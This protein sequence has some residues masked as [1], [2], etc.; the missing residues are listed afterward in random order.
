M[1]LKVF[2]KVAFR[3]FAFCGVGFRT[4]A[5][6]LLGVTAASAMN[7]TGMALP[8]ERFSERLSADLASQPAQPAG[9]HSHE[10]PASLP[11]PV[12]PATVP[13]APRSYQCCVTGHHAV[14][15]FASFTLRLAWTRAED[16]SGSGQF[17]LSTARHFFSV[18]SSSFGSPPGSF[19]LRI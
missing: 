3:R 15:P 18:V 10:L 17:S 16:A 1:R 5:V 9:C 13:P 2:R 19:A 4:V 12:V 6:L 14:I 8:A 11:L 7:A